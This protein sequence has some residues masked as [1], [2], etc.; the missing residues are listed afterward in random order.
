[1]PDQ[2]RKMRAARR[3]AAAGD[4]NVHLRAS[5]ADLPAYGEDAVDHVVYEAARAMGGS[6]SAEHG[7]GRLERPYLDYSR[8][9]AEIALM[10]HMKSALD[11]LGIL[12]PG[13]VP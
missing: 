6:I 13:K 8:S 7:T 10:R 9:P 1:M 4:S 11:P 12:N 2:W 5:L 3:G